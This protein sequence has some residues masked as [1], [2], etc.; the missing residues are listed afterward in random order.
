MVFEPYRWQ[1]LLSFQDPWADQYASGYQLAQSLIAMGRGEFAGVGLGES[2]Q[3][4]FYL[5]EA[6]TDFV[7]AIL[8]EELGLL[9]VWVVTAVFGVLVGCALAIGRRAQDA[10]LA[11]AGYFASL[12]S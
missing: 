2:I 7:F 9:G 5:P 10:G 12:A 1:R 6:H 8:A 4:L 3:K 11:F